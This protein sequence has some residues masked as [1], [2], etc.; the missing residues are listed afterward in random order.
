MKNKVLLPLLASVFAVGMSFTT[1]EVD[2]DPANDYIRQGS[3][4]HAIPEMNCQPSNNACLVQLE[5]EG[6]VYQ[7]YDAPDLSTPKPGT[8][9]IFKLYSQK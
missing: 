2:V 4:W 7:V 5:P 9:V 3:I 6:P 1:V 8:G